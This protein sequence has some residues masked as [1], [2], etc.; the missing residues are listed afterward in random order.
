MQS[1]CRLRGGRVE[2][3]TAGELGLAVAV[4]ELVVPVQRLVV[5][6]QR[7]VV[8]LQGLAA[9]IRRA[10][11]GVRRG[12]KTA[13][14]SGARQGERHLGAVSRLAARGQMAAVRAG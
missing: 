2:G 13:A 7:L 6:V 3:G 1:P 11:S 4:R 9:A 14:G 8:T 10:A 12:R 5:P